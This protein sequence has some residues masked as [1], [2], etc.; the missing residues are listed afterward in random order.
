MQAL[1]HLLRGD[2]VKSQTDHTEIL[3]LTHQPAYES[4]RRR[5]HGLVRDL[6]HTESH[7]QSARCIDT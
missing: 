2:I 4:I 3:R 7:D 1:Q 5:A 6:S